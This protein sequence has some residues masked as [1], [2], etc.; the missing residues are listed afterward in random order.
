[1]TILTSSQIQV[2]Y[3]KDCL[4]SADLSDVCSGVEASF[5]SLAVVPDTQRPGAWILIVTTSDGS[6]LFICMTSVPAGQVDG[7][8]QLEYSAVLGKCQEPDE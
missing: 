8:Q 5:K 7:V 2:W 3:G 1:M 4:A 6:A